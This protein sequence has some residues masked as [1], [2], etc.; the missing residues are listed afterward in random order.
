MCPVEKPEN[1][2]KLGKLKRT[3]HDKD[4]HSLLKQFS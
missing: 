1:L 3:G 4:T 2:W